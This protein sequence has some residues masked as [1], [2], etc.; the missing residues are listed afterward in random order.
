ML[1]PSTK[2]SAILRRGVLCL[3]L[4]AAAVTAAPLK[5]VFGGNATQLD[6]LSHEVLDGFLQ[7]MEIFLGFKE[8]A[9]DGIVHQLLAISFERFDFLR[10]QGLGFLLLLLQ[11]LSLCRNILVLRFGIVIDHELINAES[12]IL[13]GGLIND[14]LAKFAGLQEDGFVLGN[15]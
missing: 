9:G 1:L 2:V 6:R 12:D 10:G 4:A 7:V 11:R 14:G 3:M 15:G 5:I 13:H 8:T